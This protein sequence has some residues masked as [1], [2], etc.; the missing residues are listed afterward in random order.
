MNS[1]LG[2]ERIIAYWQ[3]GTRRYNP[4]GTDLLPVF[5]KNHIHV[6]VELRIPKIL[7][8]KMA[9]KDGQTTDDVLSLP[10]GS[11]L[12]RETEC[13]LHRYIGKADMIESGQAD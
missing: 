2:M 1:A 4:P 3:A 10:L 7:Q 6:S 11:T 5:V 12:M 8:E 9:G 13:F